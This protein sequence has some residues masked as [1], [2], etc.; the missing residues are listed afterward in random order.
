MQAVVNDDLAKAPISWSSDRIR[1]VSEFGLLANLL[2]A[3]LD[4]EM[5]TLMALLGWS[6]GVLTCVL[7]REVRDTR[8]YPG[9]AHLRPLIRF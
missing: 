7:P 2:I 4:G 8:R 5:L 1:C 3:W 6:V 9:R